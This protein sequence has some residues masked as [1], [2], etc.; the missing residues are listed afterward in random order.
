[1]AQSSATSVDEYLAELTL[2]RRSAISKVRD[3][4]LK[5][6]PDGYVEEMRWGM[7]SYGVPLERFPDTYNGQPLMYSALASQKR[8]MS[9]YLTNVYGDTGLRE[10]FTERYRASGKR[11]DM[12]KSCLRFRSLEDLPLGLVGEAIART[13]VDDFIDRYEASRQLTKSSSRRR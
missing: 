7:I 10:W 3:I 13:S 5:N 11:L 2:D 12:G 8:H 6:L 9:L 1:M 4:I